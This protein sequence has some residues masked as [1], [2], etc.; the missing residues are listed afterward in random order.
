MN[1]P[2][3]EFTLA[4]PSRHDLGDYGNETQAKRRHEVKKAAGAEL[5]RLGKRRGIT[6]RPAA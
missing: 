5:S 2:R 6:H 1:L 4:D 3:T